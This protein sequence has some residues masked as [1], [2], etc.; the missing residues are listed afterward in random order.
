M[1]DGTAQVAQPAIPPIRLIEVSLGALAVLLLL[2]SFW[3]ARR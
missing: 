3:V 2:A 1:Q